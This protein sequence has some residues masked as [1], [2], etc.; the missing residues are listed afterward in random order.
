MRVDA[1]V[2]Q[3]TGCSTTEAAQRILQGAVTVDGEVATAPSLQVVVGAHEVA[4][5]GKALQVD[6]VCILHHKVPGTVA[7][8]SDPRSVFQA[9]PKELARPH[10][11]CFGRLDRDTTGAMLLGTDGGLQHLVTNPAADLPKV[12]RVLLAAGLDDFD[13]CREAFRTG[14]LLSDGIVCSPADLMPGDEPLVVFVTLKEGKFHQV[15]RMIAAVGGRLQRL[16][17][18]AI[19]PFGVEDLPLGA[20]RA[21]TAREMRI[22]ASRIPPS[23]RMPARELQEAHAVPHIAEACEAAADKLA[24]KLGLSTAPD[25]LLVV[26]ATIPKGTAFSTDVCLRLAALQPSVGSVVEVAKIFVTELPK[27]VAKLARV[28]PLGF[29]HFFEAAAG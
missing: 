21:L 23:L 18:V 19:G 7:D 20:S 29:V 3:A 8:H 24:G 2:V 14:I 1:V 15:K 13:G 27:D 25:V 22:L 10:M 28:T 16:H 26:K 17:R 6:H 12:Y 9:I 5:E 11:C 4:F